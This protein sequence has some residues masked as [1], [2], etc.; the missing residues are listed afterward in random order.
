MPH[1]DAENPPEPR[2]D[3]GEFHPLATEILRSI[4]DVDVDSWGEIT[5]QHL[6]VTRHPGTINEDDD[7]ELLVFSILHEDEHELPRLSGDHVLR[8]FIQV[9]RATKNEVSL[10]DADIDG[11]T[12]P[13][14]QV[15][16][17]ITIWARGIPSE[18]LAVAR[19]GVVDT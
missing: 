17:I 19:R 1:P 6:R 9:L 16:A 18:V 7:E 15:L 12:T 3:I 14:A 11:D 5:G 10:L 8:A 13:L 2:P 4:P